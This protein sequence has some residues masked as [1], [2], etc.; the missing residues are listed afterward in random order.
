MSLYHILLK[1]N[2]KQQ[3]H[4]NVSLPHP[5]NKEGMY[6]LCTEDLHGKQHRHIINPLPVPYSRKDHRS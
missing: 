5:T 1:L 6:M 3:G 2:K 4:K